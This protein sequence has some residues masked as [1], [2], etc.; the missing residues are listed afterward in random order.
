MV[1]N[2]IWRKVCFL[3]FLLKLQNCQVDPYASSM[4]VSHA[5]QLQGS[6][7]R[8]FFSFSFNVINLFLA[9]VP[10]NDND[11]KAKVLVVQQRGRF[12][13]TSDNVDLKKVIEDV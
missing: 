1:K 11:E 5:Y 2:L 7:K 12:K 9:V 10:C 3:N 8:I 13:I 6:I 4:F